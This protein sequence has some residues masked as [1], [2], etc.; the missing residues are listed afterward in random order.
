MG[1]EPR[2][3]VNEEHMFD[4]VNHSTVSACWR[5]CEGGKKKVQEPCK[6]QKPFTDAA[7]LC[8]SRPGEKMEPGLE[9]FRLYEIQGD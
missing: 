6:E 3:G 4:N 1:L 7:D 5:K 8:C 2:R 9:Q